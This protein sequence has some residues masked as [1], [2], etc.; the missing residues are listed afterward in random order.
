MER[1]HQGRKNFDSLDIVPIMSLVKEYDVAIA[2]KDES[3]RDSFK[4]DKVNYFLY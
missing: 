2:R 1:Y 3:W 4:D